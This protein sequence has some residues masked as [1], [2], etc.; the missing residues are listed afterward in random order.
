[1]RRKEFP[2]PAERRDPA[3]VAHE[4]VV[5]AL[6]QPPDVWILRRR[7]PTRD[8][9]GGV[10]LIDGEP[11]ED[12]RKL[13]AVRKAKAMRRRADRPQHLQP[14]PVLVAKMRRTGRADGPHTMTMASR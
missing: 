1:M 3:E 12:R 14:R 10:R 9:L 5:R 2:C 6:E 13:R 7:W 8:D 4:C 11:R